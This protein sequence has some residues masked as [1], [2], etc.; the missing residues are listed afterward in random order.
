MSCTLIVI[1][2]SKTGQLE[3]DAQNLYSNT[4]W[5]QFCFISLFFSH[6]CNKKTDLRGQSR[7]GDTAYGDNGNRHFFCECK[8][9]S[10]DKR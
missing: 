10:R 4:K 8:H 1:F 9:K 7:D 6:A 3:K 2:S 5:N